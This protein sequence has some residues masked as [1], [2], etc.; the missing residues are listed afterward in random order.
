MEQRELFLYEDFSEKV[1][2]FHYQT[3]CSTLTF[4][5]TVFIVVI[6][7]YLHDYLPLCVCPISSFIVSG[8]VSSHRQTRFERATRSLATFVRSHRSLR[9]LTPQRSASLR[10]LRSLAS[11]TGSLTHF[12]HSLMGQLKFLNTCSHCYRVSREQT[13]FSS[14]LETR[15]KL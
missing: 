4:S 6:C 7:G 15:P 9:S 1:E 10:S 13:R 14:S 2:L 12:A 3:K 5:S 8:G 11:F